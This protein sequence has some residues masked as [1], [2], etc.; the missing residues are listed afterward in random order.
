MNI[1]ELLKQKEELKKLKKILEE[2][3]ERGEI[4]RPKKRIYKIGKKL[5]IIDTKE[6]RIEEVL[7]ETCNHPVLWQI[8]YNE[9][10]LEYYEPDVIK[11]HYWYYCMHCGKLITDGIK[12]KTEYIIT[13]PSDIPFVHYLRK[14]LIPEF[15]EEYY[16]ILTESDEED[17]TI[18]ELNDKLDKKFS[19]Q[20]IKTL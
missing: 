17:I 6:T 15:Q 13:A 16:K 18:E 12:P 7:Q 19:K 5:E 8:N 20:K 3:E 2:K 10:N 11:T 14:Q 1:D 9:S 4:V